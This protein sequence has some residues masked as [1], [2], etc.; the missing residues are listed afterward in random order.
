MSPEG[1]RDII[2]LLREILRE[3]ERQRQPIGQIPP[4]P[5]HDRPPGYS[6]P[7]DWVRG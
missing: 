5:F 6:T 7:G 3:L 4:R 1:E 2:A